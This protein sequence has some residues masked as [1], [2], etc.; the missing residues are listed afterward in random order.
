M[1]STSGVCR[2]AV[3]GGLAFLLILTLTGRADA[4]T[5]SFK[6]RRDFTAGGNPQSVV[7]G[8]FNGDGISDLAVA[9]HDSNNVSVLLGN[10]DGTF[11]PSMMDFGVGS[12]PS[13]IAA[14]DFNGDG[15]LDLTVGTGDGLWLLINNTTPPGSLPAPCESDADGDHAHGHAHFGSRR[16]GDDSCAE[17]EERQDDKSERKE[18]RRES[19]EHLER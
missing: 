14:A 18:E 7:K 8:D 11:K 16:R 17:S 9:N 3:E 19:C 15:K 10:G 1:K 4:Q 2:A 13:S 12:F 5:V 6:A